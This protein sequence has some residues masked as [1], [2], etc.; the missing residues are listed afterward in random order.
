MSSIDEILKNDVNGRVFAQQRELIIEL[1]RDPRLSP[2][3]QLQLKGLT[4]LLDFIADYMTDE[5]GN[6]ALIR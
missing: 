6:D 1:S 4:G 3:E 2:F 5:L